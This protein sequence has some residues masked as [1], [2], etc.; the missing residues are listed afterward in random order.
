MTDLGQTTWELKGKGFCTAC[1]FRVS[2]VQSWVPP[3][4]EIKSVLPGYTLGGYYGI[5]YDS[6]PVGPYDELIVF[7]SFV[8]YGDKSGFHISHI[9]VNNEKTLKGGFELLGVPRHLKRFEVEFREHKWNFIMYDAGR[10]AFS[11]SGRHL[12]PAFPFN[13]SIPILDVGCNETN[14]YSALF[15]TKTQLTTARLRISGDSALASLSP[16]RRLVSVAFQSLH[17]MLGLPAFV[18]AVAL[19][20]TAYATPVASVHSLERLNR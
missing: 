5:H 7:P 4:Y 8:T 17:V 10:P 12:T 15:D 14:W 13:F 6:S 3:Q 19:G 20:Q 1:L 9:F 2:K 16:T 18:P 11:S